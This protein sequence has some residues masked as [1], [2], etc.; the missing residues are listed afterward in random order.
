MFEG[1]LRQQCIEFAEKGYEFNIDLYNENRGFLD[2]LI[3][4]CSYYSIALAIGLT[5]TKHAKYEFNFIDYASNYFDDRESLDNDVVSRFAWRFGDES[6]KNGLRGLKVLKNNVYDYIPDFLTCDS[7][8][9]KKFQDMSLHVL[10]KLKDE[11]LVYGVGPWLFLGPFKIIIGTEQRLWDDPNIDAVLL[12]TGVEVNRG[13]RKL[14]REESLLVRDFD[15]NW[16]V[17]EE[18]SL[19]EGITNDQLI[20]NVLLKIA[21]QANSR[22]LHINSAF[23]LFGRDEM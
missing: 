6:L 11:E 23:Y 15:Q 10:Q 8:S 2:K 9:I 12:P 17:N 21:E 19:M 5:W 20:Q 7:K 18:G 3:S 13:I 16:L 22:V 4:S 14:I 1:L